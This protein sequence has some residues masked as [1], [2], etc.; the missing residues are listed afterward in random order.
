[1]TSQGIFIAR[2][3][4]DWFRVF[5]GGLLLVAVILNGYI[6]KRTTEAQ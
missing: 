4:T 3:N 2:W 1:M 6:R 5:L